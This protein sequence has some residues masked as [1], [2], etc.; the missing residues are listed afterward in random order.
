[1]IPKIAV[2]TLFFTLSLF[3]EIKFKKY[4]EAMQEA[5]KTNKIVVATVVSS[6]CPWCRKFEAETLKSK[7]IETAINKDFIYV[8]LNRDTDT[9]PQ[10]LSHRMMVPSTFFLDKKGNIVSQTAVGFKYPNEFMNY[11]TEALKKAKKL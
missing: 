7:V 6:T 8:I 9:M 4:D 2:A 10:P 11:L 1:M 5:A 3:A